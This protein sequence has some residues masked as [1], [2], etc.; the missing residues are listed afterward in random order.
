MLCSAWQGALSGC[1]HQDARVDRAAL[2]DV[3]S[4]KETSAQSCR[5]KAS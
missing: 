2:Y 4:T 5:Q 1:W 3:Q